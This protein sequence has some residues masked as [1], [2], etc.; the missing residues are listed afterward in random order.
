MPSIN[1]DPNKALEEQ[2]ENNLKLTG[3]TL[4]NENI[5]SDFDPTYENSKF[6]KGLKMTN[7]GFSKTSKVLTNDNFTKL[8]KLVSNKIEECITNIE[9]REFNINPKIVN[10]NNI[11][12]PYCKYNK[13]C[14]KTEKNNTYLKLDNNLEFLGGS[15][16]NLD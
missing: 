15:D 11:S 1:K 7:D 13:V 2:Y 5:L 3:Y 14:F 8:E 12:C 16:D 6:I 9:N 4:G 10:F